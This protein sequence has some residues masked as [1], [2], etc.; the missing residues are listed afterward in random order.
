MVGIPAA[1]ASGHWSGT[2]R[3]TPRGEAVMQ[4]NA[5]RWTLEVYRTVIETLQGIAWMLLV[6]FIFAPIGLRHP[7]R[8]RTQTS[9]AGRANPDPLLP[10]RTPLKTK[11]PCMCRAFGIWSRPW[12]SNNFCLVCRSSSK[13][14][15]VRFRA[16]PLARFRRNWRNGFDT[17]SS[18]PLMILAEPRWQERNGE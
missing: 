12:E 15:V 7:P 17:L 1:A 18:P 8:I 4:L 13:R 6:F 5:A 16:D 11:K 2:S 9:Q 3:R 14:V 10:A